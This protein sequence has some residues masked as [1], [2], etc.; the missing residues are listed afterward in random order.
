MVVRHLPHFKSCEQ[1][2]LGTS[3]FPYFY[4]KK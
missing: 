2:K 1:N 4:D 3:Y